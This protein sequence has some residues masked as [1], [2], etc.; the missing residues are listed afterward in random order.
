MVDQEKCPLCG[1]LLNGYV[2]PS[3]GCTYQT[4]A[5][6]ELEL[7]RQRD[8]ELYAELKGGRG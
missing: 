2:C 5:G 7:Q 8:L 6:K 4:E 3:F 1:T